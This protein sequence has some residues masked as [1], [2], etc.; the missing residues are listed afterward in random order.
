M[1]LNA[2][3]SVCE[4]QLIERVPNILQIY[5]ERQAPALISL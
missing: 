4:L 5:T 3:L 2:V 1:K